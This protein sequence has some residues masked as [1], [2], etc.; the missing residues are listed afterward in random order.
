M[1][2]PR[3][4]IT[5]PFAWTGE[6]LAANTRWIRDFTADQVGQIDRAIAAFGKTGR[7]WREADRATLPLPGLRELLAQVAEELENGVGLFRLSGV[8]VELHGEDALRA[9]YLSFGDHLGMAVP[10]SLEGDRLTAVE[11]EGAKSNSYG[12]IDDN[13]TEG[14]FRSSRARA[15]SNAGLRFHT[16]RCDV[17]SLLCTS[18]AKLGGYSKIASAV[19]VHNAMLKR[20]PDLVEELFTD[21]PRSRFGEEVNDASVHYMLP[22]FTEKNGKFATHYS[23]TYVDAAQTNPEVPRLRPA[24]DEALDK[25]AELAQELCFEMTLRPG[26][27]Q[28]LNNHVMYHA[29]D[30]YE[31]DGTTGQSRR[32]YRLWLAMANS[33]E[34]PDSFKVLFGNTSPGAI[35][36]G[37]WPPDRAYQLPL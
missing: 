10:Q 32:L 13:Q 16:D 22:V 15:F 7:P 9:F 2:S 29:R 35:R 14:G 33:R 25:L 36:G 28:L 34:L 26:D 18:Q 20:R 27:I 12:I 5:G 37:I 30:P 1:T 4:P 23:R 3:Q 19:A 24:Q 11:D 21:Y 17:V 31:D 6:E 8:P